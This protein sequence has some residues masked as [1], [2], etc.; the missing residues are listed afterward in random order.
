MNFQIIQT[1]HTI[2]YQKNKNRNNP[3]KKW[4]EALN[5]YFSKEDMVVAGGQHACD[6]MLS[7][8]N[9]RQKLMKATVRHI[10]HQP[11][12]L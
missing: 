6:K 7:T 2:Q 10:S 1:T 9:Y 5:R 4:T 8:V 3:V 12:T 11:E